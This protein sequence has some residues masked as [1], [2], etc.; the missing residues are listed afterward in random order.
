[1][2]WCCEHAS[3][4]SYFLKW[5]RRA[6][7]V[8]EDAKPKTQE[9]SSGK[10]GNSLLNV[11]A[12]SELYLPSKKS[13]GE[14]WQTWSLIMSFD[15]NQVSW[16][17]ARFPCH[18]ELLRDG[19]MRR[20]IKAHIWCFSISWGLHLAFMVLYDETFLSFSLENNRRASSGFPAH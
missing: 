2:S 8:M 1:M 14:I 17:T 15:F 6:R 7:G 9:D 20:G 11:S 18:F 16:L 19:K 10:L 4:S 12:A 5:W 3:F 13:K